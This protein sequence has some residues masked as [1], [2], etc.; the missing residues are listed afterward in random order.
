LSRREKLYEMRC[1]ALAGG[2][3]LPTSMLPKVGRRRF[4]SKYPTKEQ[5]LKKQLEKARQ[6]IIDQRLKWLESESRSCTHDRST[7]RRR[8]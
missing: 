1:L 7:A 6:D 2:N 5:R 8:W 4:Q 3:P